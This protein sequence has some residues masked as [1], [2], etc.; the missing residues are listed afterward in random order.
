MYGFSIIQN[1]KGLNCSSRI[2]TD[3]HII[4]ENHMISKFEEDKIFFQN[5]NYIVILDGVIFNKRVLQGSNSWVDTIISLYENKGNLFFNDFR[6]SFA[7][8]LYDKTLSKWIIFT[9]HLGTKFIYY[10][11]VNGIF[12]CSLM[13]DNMY[14]LLRNNNI[15]YKLDLAGAYMQLSYGFMLE[16]YTLCNEIK[17]IQPGDYIILQDN[18]LSICPYFRLKNSENLNLTEQAIIDK[19]EDLFTAAVRRQFEKDKEYGY[20]HI[21]ALSGGLDCRMTSFV[22]H[23]IGFVNQL[24]CT[25]SQSGYLD[26]TVAQ[27]MASYL[28]HEWLF[29]ALDNG[30]WLYDVDEINSITGG[31]VLFYSLAHGNSLVKYIN[32]ERLGL[33]HTGQL[34]DVTI[35]TQS[36]K[37]KKYHFG[38]GAYS[39]KICDEF[40]F[41]PSTQDL[42]EEI[43]L[44]YYRYL[45]GTNNGIQYLYN[46][47]ES[48]SPFYDLEFLKFALSIPNKYRKDHYIYKKWI[49]QKHREA[50]NFVWESS[51]ARINSFHIKINGRSQPPKKIFRRGLQKIRIIPDDF[52]SKHNMNP[53]AYYLRNNED[54]FSY[55]M[56]YYS[57]LDTIKD[58]SLKDL[59]LKIR[60]KGDTMEKI[61]AVTLLGAIKLYHLS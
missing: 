51:G 56:S 35:A 34:G 12:L 53:I 18:I 22:A 55:L 8:A 61:Q 5:S 4:C 47:T 33:V 59:L 10:S 13:M 54:L 29:K 24:N 26:E 9:D 23:N 27:E 1:G 58:E 42:D 40:S 20:K 60:E 32:F 41:T 21:V 50:G 25:F 52:N 17:K 48:F 11:Y 14:K 3:G 2:I 46:Y 7:G 44:Y 43:G 31:N 6:G 45:N 38:D 37:E 36:S 30:L 15:E 16:D 39:K 19:I 28:K 57:Y 49:M